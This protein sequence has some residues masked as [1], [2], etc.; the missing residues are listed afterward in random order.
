MGLTAS[1]RPNSLLSVWTDYS[2]AAV[3]FLQLM[4]MYLSACNCHAFVRL[5]VLLNCVRSRNACVFFFILLCVAVAVCWCVGSQRDPQM[6]A[7]LSLV[8]EWIASRTSFKGNQEALCTFAGTSG[9][10]RCRHTR[11]SNVPPTAFQDNLKEDGR[12]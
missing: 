10:A 12:N 2:R 8:T 6:M 11:A 5:L 7:V 3:A 1:V 9:D 4:P